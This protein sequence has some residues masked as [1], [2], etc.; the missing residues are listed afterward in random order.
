MPSSI[1]Q[2][3]MSLFQYSIFSLIQ[4]F[5]P[6]HHFRFYLYTHYNTSHITQNYDAQTQK[7][8]EKLGLNSIEELEAT[9]DAMDGIA[10]DGGE[11]EEEEEQDDTDTR[12]RAAYEN[13]C[14]EFGKDID[15]K[16]F[17]TFSKNF[18]AMEAYASD[19]GKTMQ[20]NMYADFTEE[21]YSALIAEKEAEKKAEEEKKDAEAKAAADA[22]EA[23][24]KAAADAKEAEAKAA[25]DAKEAEAKAAADAKEAEAK[26]VADAKAAEE[27][28]KFYNV[29]NS[30]II[31]VCG[32]W[33]VLFLSS[34]SHS[35]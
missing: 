3:R 5:S 6:K 27:A 28:G 20:L 26:A 4:V 12:V 17:P 16:R 22:K 29:S 2:Y 1:I 18:L 32:W 11:L 35:F 7:L 10:E 31:Y 9:L 13:W 25:A 19:N 33:K 21:E 14:K 15:D 24:A 23:E 8:M 30:K 34:I